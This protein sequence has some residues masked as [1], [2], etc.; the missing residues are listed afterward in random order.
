LAQTVAHQGGGLS[1][2][3]FAAGY[4]AWQFQSQTGKQGAGAI[5][6]FGGDNVGFLQNPQGA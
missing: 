3:G 6:A 2:V 5:R 4:E 1:A